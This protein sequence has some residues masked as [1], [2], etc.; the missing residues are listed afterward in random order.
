MN[1]WTPEG[2]KDVLIALAP[3]LSK[4]VRRSAD[5]RAVAPKNPQTARYEAVALPE[6]GVPRERMKLRTAES[7]EFRE[8]SPEKTRAMAE[9]LRSVIGDV[10]YDTIGQM[11]DFFKT[12][13]GFG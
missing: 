13:E 9:E 12:H 5:T 2:V 8:I 3:F 11:A 6:M 10:R 4:L 7:S 1:T